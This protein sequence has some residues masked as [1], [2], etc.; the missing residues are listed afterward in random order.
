MNGCGYMK[1]APTA[2]HYW[3][4]LVNLDRMHFMVLGMKKMQLYLS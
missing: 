4:L 1:I 3:C 2:L